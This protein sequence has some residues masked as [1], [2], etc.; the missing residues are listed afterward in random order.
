MFE[1]KFVSFEPQ[2]GGFHLAG[3]PII[4]D[5]ADYEGL[6]IA[7]KSLSEDLE[8]VTGRKSDIVHDH[9]RINSETAIILGSLR[10]SKHIQILSSEGKLDTSE[11]EDKW[12][13]FTTSVV[14]EPYSGIGTALVLAGS[15][16]RGAIFAAYT[17]S[18]QIGISPYGITGLL[19]DYYAD[20]G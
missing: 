2:T 16:K 3:S 6:K 19:G 10:R 7:A 4:V 17:L 5:D 18:E 12:E 14:L 11:I 1:P 13:S 8:K 20:T 15:D 9:S